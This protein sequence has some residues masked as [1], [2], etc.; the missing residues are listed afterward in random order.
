MKE[1]LFYQKLNDQK[2]KCQACSHYCIISNGKRGICG[3]KENQDGV[4]YALNYGKIIARNIDP[5]EKKPLYHFLPGS[6]SYSIAT[7]GCNFRCLNCQN[8]D[9]SQASKEGYFFNKKEIPG[10]GMSPEGIVADALKT[11]CQSIAYTYTEP[12]IFYEF[13]KDCMALA[14]TKGLK[15]VWVSNGYFSKEV[16][17]DA[18]SLI[19]AANIDLKFFSNKNYLKVCG[20]KLQP[21]LDNLIRLKESDIWLEI[22]TLL[23]PGFNDSE[24]ELKHIAGFIAEEIGLDVPW[25]VSAFYPAFKMADVPPT[26][27]ASILKAVNIGKESGLNYVY[28]G[29]I[30]DEKSSTTFCPHCKTP[31]IKRI[32]YN[33]K[34]MDFGGYCPNCHYKVSGTF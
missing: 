4:L 12:T 9:I 13:A 7:V 23:I 31:V 3:V 27:T 24:N 19:D 20:T 25:H 15:N 6:Q 1:A 33:I 28:G 5:I 32:G 29:N 26:A 8:A 16:I 22:T 21:V 34:R 17:N 2:V 30:V 18:K 14:R 11:N 10:E